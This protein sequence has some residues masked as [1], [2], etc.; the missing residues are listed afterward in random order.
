MPFAKHPFDGEGAYR[1]GGRWSSAGTRLAYASEHASLAMLEY[2]VHIELNEAP[3]DLVLVAADIP[4]SVPRKRITAS[5]LPKKWAQTPAPPGLAQIGD[6][7]VHEQRACVLIVPSALAPQEMNWLL[8]PAHPAFA[9]IQIHKP[10][11]FRYDARM[12]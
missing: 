4:G 7:F 9:R 2:F 8:N 10:R 11:P 6:T 12:L 5:H 3:A 1:F